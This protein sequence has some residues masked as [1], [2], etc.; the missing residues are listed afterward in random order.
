MSSPERFEEPRHRHEE[1]ATTM[2]LKLVSEIVWLFILDVVI[3]KSE[4]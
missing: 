3:I 2:L 1:P 4:F